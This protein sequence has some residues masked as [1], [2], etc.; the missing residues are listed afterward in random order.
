M[1]AS[2][3]VLIASKDNS[4][5]T[6]FPP[7]LAAALSDM[8]GAWAQPTAIPISHDITAQLRIQLEE[9]GR[10]TARLSEIETNIEVLFEQQTYGCRAFAGVS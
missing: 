7:K 2:E 9:A 8:G 6:G 10:L 3:S 4:M 5:S 1:A